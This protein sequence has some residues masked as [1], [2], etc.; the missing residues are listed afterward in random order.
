MT[1]REQP[2]YVPVAEKWLFGLIRLASGEW[3]FDFAQAAEDDEGGG[4]SY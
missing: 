4:G 1:A 2:A 3:K